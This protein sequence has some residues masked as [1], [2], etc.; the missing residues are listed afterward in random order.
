MTGNANPVRRFGKGWGCAV[1]GFAIAFGLAWS[2]AAHAGYASMIVDGTTGEVLN[3]VNPD[4]IN[5]PASLTKLMTMYIAFK[6][7]QEGRM[8]MNTQLHVSAWAAGKSPT[9]L[10]L[11]AGTTVSMHD[12]ILGMITKSANDA[13][14]VV[15]ENIGG[16]EAGFAQMMNAEARRLGMTNTH[17]DNASGLP[18]PGQITTARDLVKLS[19]AVYR[20]FPQY[21]PLFATREFVFQGHMVHGHNN[22]MYH[23]PGMD[24]LKTG[25][26]NASGFNLASTAVRGGHRLFGV[27]MGSTSAGI[28]DRLMATLLDN[29]FAHKPTD[30]ILVAEAGG[31]RPG[32]ARR[33]LASLSPIGS[34]EAATPVAPRKARIAA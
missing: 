28:R 6:T 15:A 21:F 4:A 18:D 26:I 19:M 1:A 14:T 12:C 30:P 11:R 20:D 25:F 3:E 24:G 34:A 31:V 9:K 8:N 32:A 5:H 33:M 13:A 16:S 22:L 23:Y 27:V 29:G 10:N 2:G 17:Y 7:M